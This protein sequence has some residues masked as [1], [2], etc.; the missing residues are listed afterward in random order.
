M[1]ESTSISTRHAACREREA[2]V[3]FLLEMYKKQIRLLWQ[4]QHIRYFDLR[5]RV[6]ALEKLLRRHGIRFPPGSDAP[7]TLPDEGIGDSDEE[8]V[9]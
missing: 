5:Q 9:T 3:A 4:Q 7:V 6:Q 1:A 8:V 2:N